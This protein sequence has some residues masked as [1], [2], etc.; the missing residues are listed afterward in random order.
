ML[1]LSVTLF[2]LATSVISE[3]FRARV[4]RVKCLCLFPVK[5]KLLLL[6]FVLNLRCLYLLVDLFSIKTFKSL[7]KVYCSSESVF[8]A[9]LYEY[10][11]LCLCVLITD[12]SVWHSHTLAGSYI[13]L[14]LSGIHSCSYT[15]ESSWCLM[16]F[17]PHACTSTSNPVYPKVQYACRVPVHQHVDLAPAIKLTER[18]PAGSDVV[19]ICHNRR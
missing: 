18:C 15:R 10:V 14:L 6:F 7:V 2:F 16:A 5:M 1:K 8:V 12:S 19:V 3:Y 13:R 4:A 9:H 11:L 17:R